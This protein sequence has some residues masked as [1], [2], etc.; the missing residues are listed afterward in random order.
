MCPWA[1]VVNNHLLLVLFAPEEIAVIADTGDRHPFQ[2]LSHREQ[3]AAGCRLASPTPQ[4]SHCGPRFWRSNS[5]I[6][7]LNKGPRALRVRGGR[8]G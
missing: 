3:T 7:G 4:S 2:I 6:Y 8:S 1:G 5:D